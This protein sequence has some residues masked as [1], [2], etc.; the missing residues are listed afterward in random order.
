MFTVFYHLYRL[1]HRILTGIPVRMG[2]FSYLPWHLA[3]RLVVCG[4]LWSHYAAAVVASRTGY[5]LVPC[6]RGH[7]VRG[8]SKMGVVALVTHGLSA[9]AVFSDRVGVRVLTATA[10]ASVLA[11]L[12]LLLVFVLRCC[13]DLAIPGWATAAGGLLVVF[14]GELALLSVLFTFVILAGRNRPTVIPFRD[15]PYF[16]EG[17]TSLWP[18]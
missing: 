15:Y 10:V 16:I 13:T 17:A 8:R 9:V 18:T 2:N 6:P 1:F 4:E 7:R 5:R 3:S 14:L 12:G 11:V